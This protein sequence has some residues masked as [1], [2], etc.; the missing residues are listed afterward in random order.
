MLDL[1]TLDLDGTL[2]ETEPLKAAS[3]GWAAH[4]LRPD[5]DPAEVEAAYAP[6]VGRSREEIARGLARQFGLDGA[7][8]QHDGTVEPWR[9]FVGLRLGRYR[10]MID[11]GPLVRERARPEAVA[12]ARDSRALARH[13]A[14]VTTSDRRNATAVLAGLGLGDAFDTTVT[15]S[16]VAR[17]KPDPE[18]YRLAL[19]RLN[20]APAEALA[21]E[22]SPAGIRAALA[23]GMGVLAVPTDYTRGAVRE[24]VERGELD[25]RAVVGAGGLAAAVRQRAG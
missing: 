24:M 7:A 23:A 18:G 10:A 25:A 20:A 5:L 6:Y 21:V 16:D 1:L 17:T 15:S 3:Y 19:A 13:V 11:D 9:A 4:Q 2:A 14:L 22:D 8:R 12:L